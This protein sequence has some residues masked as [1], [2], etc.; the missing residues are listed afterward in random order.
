MDH[1]F[2]HVEE[3]N[4]ASPLRA[5]LESTNMALALCTASSP[6]PT[7]NQPLPWSA[8]EDARGRRAGMAPLRHCR[9]SLSWQGRRTAPR[10]TNEDVAAGLLLAEYP[11]RVAGQ[12][13]DGDEDATK[14]R[15]A[16]AG[17][18]DRRQKA[19]RSVY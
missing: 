8:E 11:P 6:G 10:K 18:G 17:E 12:N 9:T 1:F 16:E 7:K 14:T 5:S 2:L 3:K 15:K 4:P 13:W 19:G